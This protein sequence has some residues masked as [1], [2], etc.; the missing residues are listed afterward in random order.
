M[1][2][3][4]LEASTQRRIEHRIRTQLGITLVAQ[5]RRQEAAAQFEAA[6]L[7]N[8]TSSHTSKLLEAHLFLNHE[9]IHRHCRLPPSREGW[10]EGLVQV[11]A[12]AP[13]NR[14]GL[15]EYH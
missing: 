13:L 7:L 10:E 1:E 11:D 15:G 2:E 3:D 4:D 5:H 8:P 14:S 6:L 12:T 9:Y